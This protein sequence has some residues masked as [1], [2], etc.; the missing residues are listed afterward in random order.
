MVTEYT[1]RPTRQR[2]TCRRIECPQISGKQAAA[3]Y[4]VRFDKAVEGVPPKIIREAK[5]LSLATV[6]W[7]NTTPYP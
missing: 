7:P 3:E 6:P 2:R 4:K 1:V 5:R